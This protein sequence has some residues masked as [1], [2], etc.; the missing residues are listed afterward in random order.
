[1]QVSALRLFVR[2]LAAAAL[3]AP[4]FAFAQATVQHLSGTLSV[5]R[6]D[7]SVLALAERSDVFV[8]DVIS[9]ER[10]S[11][12]QLRFTDGGQVTLRPNTQVKIETYGYEEGR[13]ERDNFAMQLFKGGLRSLTGLIGKRATNRSAYR[14]VT[15]TATIGIRG[16]DYSAID[17]PAPPGRP[18]RAPE[19]AAAG[20][21]RDGGRRADRAYLG[22]RGAAGRHR[23]GGLLHQYQSA[24][25][26]RP[27]A[28][29]SSAGHPAAQLR[30]DAEDEQHQRRF[31][32]GVRGPVGP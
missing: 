20:G 8:G 25:K 31:E 18:E 16:T 4:L 17:I 28:A 19:P 32:P 6:P 15:S 12:A 10:D 24:S 11:Y 5:Q 7:G 22:G 1:M 14:M 23:T 2:A 29:E 27:P 9:T 21:V 26:A 30:A 13:P 3:L